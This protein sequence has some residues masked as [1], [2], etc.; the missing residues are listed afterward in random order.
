MVAGLCAGAWI[1]LRAALATDLDG[2]VAINPQLYWQPGDPVEADIIGET[3]VRRQAEI[4]RIKRRGAIGLWWA[5]DMVGARD[6]AAKWLRAL[7]RTGTPVMALFARGDDG[8][9]F[10]EDRTARAWAEVQRAGVVDLVVVDE[11][12]H[13]MHRH[14]HRSRVVTAI[15]AWLDRTPVGRVSPGRTATRRRDQPGGTIGTER[16]ALR[17]RARPSG[18]P[19]APVLCS[20]MVRSAPGARWNQESSGR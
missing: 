14:W 8:L 17:A 1:A 7:A 16:R 11:I 13:P 6:P 20:P 2:V 4:R 9:E 3:R 19:S 10:L 12:D 18:G 5:L 15:H